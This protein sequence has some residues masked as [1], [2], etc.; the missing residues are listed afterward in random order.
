[1]VDVPHLPLGRCPVCDAADA[2]VTQREDKDEYFVECVN[3][4]VYHVSRKAFRHFEYL[5][6]RADPVGLERLAQLAATL[7]ARPEG[8]Q[9]RLEYDRWQELLKTQQQDS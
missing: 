4:G 5:R 9:V 2:Y 3:C 7:H 1:M 8:A 6:W